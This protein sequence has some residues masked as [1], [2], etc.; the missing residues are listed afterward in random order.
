MSRFLIVIFYLISFFIGGYAQASQQWLLLAEKSNLDF[1]LSSTL[2]EVNGNSQK[3]TGILEQNFSSL[4]GFVDVDVLGLTTHNPARDRDMYRMFDSSIFPEIHFVFNDTDFTRI[5]KYHDGDIKFSGLMTIHNISHQ[6]SFVS[7][8]HM[9][10]DMLVCE[11][12]MLIHLKEYS[13]KPPSVLWFIHVKD[14]VL[15]K[16]HMVFIKKEG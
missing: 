16:Y 9:Q 1:T 3:V 15:V 12:N 11:G 7:K 10:G 8:G 5:L 4:R 2:H 6:L 13:L 14:E